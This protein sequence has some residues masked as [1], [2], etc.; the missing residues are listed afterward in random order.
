M[1]NNRE[2]IHIHSN[3]LF[4]FTAKMTT[5]IDFPLLLSAKTG[6]MERRKRLSSSH[7]LH[8]TLFHFSS[9]RP[10]TA[11]FFILVVIISIKVYDDSGGWLV[12]LASAELVQQNCSSCIFHTYIYIGSLCGMKLLMSYTISGACLTRKNSYI[13]NPQHASL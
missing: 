13:K 7:F 8:K 5:E 11:L 3:F 2:H 1:N 4:F 6:G 12:V 10:P 9:I